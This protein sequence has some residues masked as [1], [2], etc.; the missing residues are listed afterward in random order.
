MSLQIRAAW[1]TRRQRDPRDIRTSIPI[2]ALKHVVR[3]DANV[4]LDK[5]ED[6][7]QQEM[8]RTLH[9][10]GIQASVKTNKFSLPYTREIIVVVPF[11]SYLNAV[12]NYSK[13][14]RPIVKKLMDK[15]PRRIRFYFWTDLF[16]HGDGK[17]KGETGLKYYFRYYVHD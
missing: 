6:E 3:G 7:I 5:F 4:T 12:F 9:N 17:R 1:N 15:N 14:F 10:V 13:V 16:E 2:G 8:I 11:V